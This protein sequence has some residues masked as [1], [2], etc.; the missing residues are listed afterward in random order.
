MPTIFGTL[1]IKNESRWIV[2]VIDAIRPVC[3]RI[4][5]LDDSSTDFTPELCERHGGEQ[6]CV[7]RSPFADQPLDETRDRDFLMQRTMQCIS[8]IHL[9]GNPKSPF[10]AL[11][12][13]GDEVLA[14]S[15]LGVITDAVRDIESH[16]FRL[17]IL[18]L[19]NDRETVRVD[20]VYRTFSRPSLYRL[21]NKNFRFQKT[22]WGGNF[23]CS[24]VPQELLHGAI[25]LTDAPLLHL[26]YMDA[27]D[28]R[29]KLDWYN[30]IDPNNEVEDCYRHMCQGDEGGEPAERRLKHAGPLLLRKLELPVRISGEGISQS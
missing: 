6:V 26:G 27:A 13:D 12:I 4:F 28:R 7:I 16:C 1:R 15:G 29:R 9:R 3:E 14:P 23:H 18:Y 17:P 8:D 2:E 21:F 30:Q 20:G 19:W 11:A 24:S 25:T 10:W 22:P 5:I